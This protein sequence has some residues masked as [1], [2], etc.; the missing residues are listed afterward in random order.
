VTLLIA[1]AFHQL[2]EGL[3]LGGRIALLPSLSTSALA[4][5]CMALS[6]ALTTPIGI[7]IGIG[8]RAS[9]DENDGRTALAIGV[10][11]SMSA[12]I[13]LYTVRHSAPFVPAALL[14]LTRACPSA[15]SL[16]ELLAGDFIFGPLRDASTKQCVL[17]VFWLSAG[18]AAMS[19]IGKWA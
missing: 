7:A 19:L 16:V 18:A 15:Q 4:K 11:N 6:Y 9:F 14:A 3:A 8:A 10:L 12:G 17:A 13:L 5:T 2:F 1:M